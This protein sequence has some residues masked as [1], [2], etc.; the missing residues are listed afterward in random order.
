LDEVKTDEEVEQS[1]WAWISFAFSKK[2]YNANT[3]SLSFSLTGGNHHE[4]S[5]QILFSTADWSNDFSFPR[6]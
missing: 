6:A 1:V 3:P 2:E 4:A 5:N